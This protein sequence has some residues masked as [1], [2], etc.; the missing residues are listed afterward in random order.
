MESDAVSK[1]MFLLRGKGVSK[2]VVIGRAIIMDET[3]LEIPHY[4]IDI[5]E[6]E[7]ECQRLDKAIEQVYH[8]LEALQRELPRDAP[9]ELAPLLN[10]H[11]LL[12]SDP[13]LA[14]ECKV[15]IQENAYNAEWA[16]SAQ[17][18][19]LAHQF[20]AMEDAYLRER[21]LDIRQV[22]ELIIDE[23]QGGGN[24][25]MRLVAKLS[26]SVTS[27]V[28]ARD[29]TPADMV[30]MR[31]SQFAGF[32]TDLGGPTS[33]TAI[34]AR[35]MGVPAVVGALNSRQLIHDH[36]L[37]VIDGENGG[38]IVNPSADILRYYQKKEERLL[39]DKSILWDKRNLDSISLDK[40]K[41]TVLGNIENP[42]E[43]ADVIAAGGQ[44]IGL[45]RTEFL[46][47]GRDDLPSEDEQYEAYASVLKQLKGKPVTIRTLDIGSD[48]SL[49]GEYSAVANPALG[50]RAV[51]YC[52][53]RPDLFMTQLKALLR[54]ATHGH[55]KILV[56]MVAHMHEIVSVKKMLAE[57]VFEL[58]REGKE[59]SE[60]Y[61]LG[62]MV[63]IPAVAYVV[64]LVLAE[65]DFVSIGTNDLIQYMLAID[66]VD[67][68]VA[69]LFDPLH[70]AVV[71]I[72]EH[73]IKTGQ[74]MGKPVSI[75]GE[76]A[77]DSL[78]TRLL[79][80]LGLR[81]FSMGSKHIPEIKHII[82]QSH[83]G[84]ITERVLKS[85][86]TVARVELDDLGYIVET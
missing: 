37:I 78:Y 21:A 71:R 62:V 73:V 1:A 67:S 45:Y 63:E 64:D 26:T 79:L 61:E 59:F 32:I 28:V 65:V 10:V 44:G 40:Q 56:P 13:I 25:P 24:K 81:E 70:P 30:R 38:I 66:R 41:V 8:E 33:H 48:K 49:H 85:F 6:V 19:H 14:Q 57:A 54:A 43:A 18:Q 17:G 11:S 58:Q 2:G 72:I 23:L 22:I 35:S 80:G 12:V 39:K 46:F 15:L 20:E 55:L 52:L 9:K 34:V 36:D 69:H 27:I 75:C 50:L 53:A 76:M 60:D 47:M 3:D 29:I 16:L 31:A 42:E 51:R 4:H 83:I 5:N 84:H 82:R 77:G 68:D 74:E 7:A 86:K